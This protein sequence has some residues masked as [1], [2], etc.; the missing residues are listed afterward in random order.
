[1]GFLRVRSIVTGL[2]SV[3]PAFAAGIHGT[4]TD[5][6]GGSV[7]GAPIQARNAATRSVYKAISGASGNYT[8]AGL[9]S[10]T[11]DISV[12]GIGVR[13][14][15]YERSGIELKKVDT[16]VDIRLDWGPN[17]GTPG[18]DFKTISDSVR[19]KSPPPS[20]PVPRT[21]EGKPD[22][23][24]VWSGQDDP[25]P[26]EPAFLPWAKEVMKH[27]AEFDKVVDN[28]AAHCLPNLVLTEGSG[29]YKF[30]QTPSML[31]LMFEDVI[32]YRQV[33][34]D[35][36]RHPQNWEPSWHGHSI[37][38][39]ER[40][41]LVVDTVGFNDR[42]WLDLFPHTEML[43]LVERYRRRDLGHL[44]VQITIADPGTF[45]KPWKRNNVWELAPKEDVLE[46]VC[47]ENNKDLD[48]LGGK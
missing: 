21:P 23:S 46:Y 9:P 45:V 33:F 35:G 38:K 15:K 29:L 24:G 8:L 48:H 10:G 20:G 3:L 6:D 37:G 40:D 27:R 34:L 30:A 18:D 39:W 19:R 4:V 14:A 41:A 7:A 26:E 17:L 42:S 22:L 13:L 31:I 16:Q 11:Y 32:G 12:P 5:P 36:R 2:F 25:H 43:H 44:D 28:P 1:M 47:N